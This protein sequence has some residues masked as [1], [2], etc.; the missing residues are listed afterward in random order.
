MRING[1]VMR[2]ND[3]ETYGKYAKFFYNT[4]RHGGPYL[5]VEWVDDINKATVVPHFWQ[6]QRQS[7]QLK[8]ATPIKVVQQ[9]I[10]KFEDWE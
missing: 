6:C 10:V 7:Q 9:V 2:S 5:E 3:D 8:R 4:L 1:Y